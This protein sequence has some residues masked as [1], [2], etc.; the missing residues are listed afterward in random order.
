MEIWIRVDFSRYRVEI[1]PVQ[2]LRSTDASVFFPA[3]ST[4][5]RRKGKTE[6]REAKESTGRRYFA[7]LDEAAEFAK[8]CANR[9][10]EDAYRAEARA[11][12]TLRTLHAQIDSLRAAF[13]EAQAQAA[14]GPAEGEQGPQDGPQAA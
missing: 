3:R 9:N 14:E 1:V 12:E 11:N 6:Y 10:L 5:D 2:A 8:T 7:D 4:W 13:A